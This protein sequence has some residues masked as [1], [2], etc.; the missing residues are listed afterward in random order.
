MGSFEKLS[1]LVIGVIVAM[2]LVVA[3]YTWMDKPEE[4]PSASSTIATAPPAE[5]PAPPPPP[6][7]LVGFP[8]PGESLP[9]PSGAYPV[10]PE[11]AAPVGPAP[12]SAPA[13]E[14]APA[15]EPAPVPP[16]PAF[17]THKVRSG[18][19]LGSISKQYFDTT[20]KWQVIAAANPGLDPMRM[21]AGTE[22]KI[23]VDGTAPAPEVA[24]A[25]AAETPAGGGSAPAPGSTYKVRRGETL[26]T[27]AKKV[28]GSKTRWPDIWI[29]NLAKLEDPSDIME[30]MTILL[31]Q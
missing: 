1:V 12:E 4:E 7:S 15:P 16:A 27:I 25:P 2:I 29:A 30:G 8:T 13:P 18:E 19:T 22:I 14:A 5:D 26:E 17:K 11:I 28:Y 9:L 20:S 3:F 21:R 23:P 24:T 6:D 31:P 10:G